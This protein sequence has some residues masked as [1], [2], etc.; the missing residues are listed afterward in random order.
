MLAENFVCAT[1]YS[2]VGVRRALVL[3]C[4]QKTLTVALP[5]LAA[6]AERCPQLLGRGAADAAALPCVFVHLL[7]TA[8][9]CVLVSWWMR[10]D[11]I[12]RAQSISKLRQD[13][14]QQ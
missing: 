6:L 8:V 4:S 9:D 3:V 5:V 2:G 14:Q 1:A 12:G 11:R 13:L 7:Q 10:Q